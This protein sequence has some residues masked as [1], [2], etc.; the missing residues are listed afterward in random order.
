MNPELVS[1]REGSLLHY[2]YDNRSTHPAND[3]AKRHV[4]AVARTARS[5]SHQGK[6]K[7]TSNANSSEAKSNC[8]AGL[9]MTRSV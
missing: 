1:D 7:Q 3:S 5:S 2:M 8:R 4:T 6:H 9:L